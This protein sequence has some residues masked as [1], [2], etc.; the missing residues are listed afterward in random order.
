MPKRPSRESAKDRKVSADFTDDGRHK[1]KQ[2]RKASE[3]VV[4]VVDTTIAP[5]DD[6]DDSTYVPE[7][8]ELPDYDE[9]LQEFLKSLEPKK[10]KAKRNPRKQ[11]VEAAIKLTT[12]ERTYFE[13]LPLDKQKELNEKKKKW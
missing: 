13:R 11:V 7:E 9:F 5:D 12:K 6:D 10:N 2:D 8:N 3:D 4:W 1:K